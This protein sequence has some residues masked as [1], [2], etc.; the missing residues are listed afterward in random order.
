VKHQQLHRQE[1]ARRFVAVFDAGDDVLEQLQQLCARE[2][3][4]S[5]ML[6]GIGGFSNATVGYYDMKAK[7][8][9]PIAVNEQVE[10]VSF[11]GNVTGYQGKPKLHVHCIVGHR[12]GHTT[13]GHL[14]SATVRPTLELFIDELASPLRRTDRP[15]IGIP[16]IEL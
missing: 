9:E 10:V 11:L 16:L 7:R 13:A 5:A 15:E 12:D 2:S 6:A 8:Y 14:L 4:A 3:I 1:Q